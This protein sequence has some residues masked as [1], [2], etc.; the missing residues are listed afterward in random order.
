MVASFSG[1]AKS[2]A[3]AL[4]AKDRRLAGLDVD[5]DGGREAAGH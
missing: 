5:V 4:G 3:S 2:P 1:A